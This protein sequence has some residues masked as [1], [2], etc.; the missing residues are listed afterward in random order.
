M[1]SG[2]LIYDVGLA[3]MAIAAMA[4][5]I[6]GLILRWKKRKLTKCFDEEYGKTKS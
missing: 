6:T 1:M 3:V 2:E 5:V 4:A